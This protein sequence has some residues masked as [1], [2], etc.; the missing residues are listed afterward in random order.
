MMT[1]CHV[2]ASIPNFLVL[3]FHGRD[4]SWWEEMC[5]GD[6]PFIRDGWMEVSEAPGNGVELNDEVA[7][8][9]LWEGDQYFD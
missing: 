6:R 1:A 7:K 2:L 8:G 5:V 9:L 3:E 4:V